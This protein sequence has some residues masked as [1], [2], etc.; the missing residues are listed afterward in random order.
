MKNRIG[1]EIALRAMIIVV[2][3]LS[4]SI[5]TITLLGSSIPST[6]AHN[7][8]DTFESREIEFLGKSEFKNIKPIDEEDLEEEDKDFE[9]FSTEMPKKFIHPFEE[10]KDKDSFI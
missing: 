5:S 2:L 7:S 9:R 10:I 3:L 1:N 8:K 6:Y 4:S